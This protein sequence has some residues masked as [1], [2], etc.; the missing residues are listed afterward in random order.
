MTATGKNRSS[1]AAGGGNISLVP[2]PRSH[3]TPVSDIKTDYELVENRNGPGL[4][5]ISSDSS[6]WLLPTWRARRSKD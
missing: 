4:A 2:P 1:T 6:E 5:G 3:E